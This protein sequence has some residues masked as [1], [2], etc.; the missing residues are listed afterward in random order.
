MPDQAPNSLEI[1]RVAAALGDRYLIDGALG[2]GGAG[3]V[4]L[5]REVRHW[6]RVAI[7]I[8]DPAVAARLGNERFE[9]EIRITARLQHPNILPLLDSGRVDGVPYYVM[10][11]LEAGSLR[12][13]LEQDGPMPVVA[14]VRLI[15]EVAD[16]LAAAHELGIT[17]RDVKPENI[18]LSH[19]HAMIA[20]FGV[21]RSVVESRMFRSEQGAAI[22]TPTY[23]SPE[24]AA[25]DQ[26]VDGRADQFSLA[27]VLHELLT[28]RPP[29]EG[30]TAWALIASRFR[31]PGA[32]ARP[33]HIPVPLWEVLATALAVSPDDRFA[34]VGD[35]VAALAACV[36]IPVVAADR[37]GPERVEQPSRL[38]R[39]AA[40][41]AL[42]FIGPATWRL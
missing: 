10:P 4:Y 24:Q 27:C 29:F 32:L 15:S 13:R 14:A 34:S 42:L 25:G 20:D 39:F 21:A 36:S 37:G 2:R 5:G 16:A 1:S 8:L 40:S 12:Q 7:K 17:H 35:L 23:M 22:G 41:L 11:Y 9:R 3:T 18:L 38:Q 28:G 26:V 19:G 31:G 6:R 33:E 30:E